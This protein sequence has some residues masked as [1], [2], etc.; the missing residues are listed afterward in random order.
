MYHLRVLGGVDLRDKEGRSQTG[1]LRRRKPFALFTYLALADPQIFLQRDA[2]C[3]LFWP[4][5]DQRRARASLRQ[6][7]ATIRRALPEVLEHRGD[8]EVRLVP[9]M[10][11]SDVQEFREAAQSGETAAA[12]AAYAGPFLNAF[13]VRGSWEFGEWVDRVRRELEAVYESLAEVAN[14]VAS[15]VTTAASEASTT[16]V[17]PLPHDTGPGHQSIRVDGSQERAAPTR[18][19]RG[20]FLVP[21]GLAGA[22]VLLFAALSN[23]EARF[24]DAGEEGIR[25]AV[26][27]PRYS[28]EDAEVL[29]LAHGLHDELIAEIFRIADLS[30]VPGATVRQL[31]GQE[32]PAADLATQVGARYLLE[33]SIQDDGGRVRIHFSLADVNADSLVWSEA[34]D[35]SRASLIDIRIAV[36]AE[37]QR[38]L[39]SRLVGRSADPWAGLSEEAVEDFLLGKGWGAV[40]GYGEDAHERWR[41][42]VQHL[43]R[44]VELEPE[45]GRAWATLAMV[46]LR[47][48][49]L[50][51]DPTRSRIERADSALAQAR[52][53]GAGE[54]DTRHAE[55]AWDYYVSHDYRNALEIARGL[56]TERDE[57]DLAQ[58]VYAATRRL[59]DFEATA[60]F[61]EE[62]LE[63]QPHELNRLG[64]ELVNTYM[65][66]GRYGDARRVLER[67]EATR[68]E[69]MCV[70]RLS[71]IFSE[72][73]NTQ[74]HQ[75]LMD[76]CALQ[77]WPLQFWRNFFT[78]RYDAAR[79]AVEGRRDQWINEQTARFPLAFW[80]IQLAR[81]VGEGETVAALV[82]PHVPRL[83]ALVEELPASTRRRQFLS[84]AYAWQGLPEEALE[85]ARIALDLASATGNQWTGVPRALDSMAQTWMI[86]GDVDR[87]FE[88]IASVVEDYPNFIPL[89]RL[90]DDPI[91][92]P[93]RAHPGF[94]ALL[95]SVEA[96]VDPALASGW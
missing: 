5:S 72:S 47:M 70:A 68:G 43:E 41:L 67:M 87:A 33:S 19:R 23:S 4:D 79:T 76:R 48:Y 56:L 13:H 91:L 52:R 51:A 24:A 60:A 46:H 75:D 89:G 86:L 1:L 15:R 73:G 34:Y 7:L 80:E 69:S 55:A 20:R 54:F 6:C 37:V 28:G 66:M 25:I 32:T 12:R 22:A 62:R 96:S 10:V 18:P 27:T 9:G 40:S 93:V 90:R 45:F 31:E 26:T 35:R 83:E 2:L 81:A 38:G 53:F 77:A 3:A 82:E 30:P 11:R 61:M 14:P 42:A 78:R 63:Y 85:Q 57:P 95:A 74:A 71:L 16:P 17:P 88:T 58:L 36:S 92:D 49:W 94:P 59:G 50:N 39:S 21:V 65:R 64:G 29:A 8:E 44:A 84:W